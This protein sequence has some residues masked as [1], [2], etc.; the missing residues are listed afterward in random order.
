LVF[1]AF[2][3][4]AVVVGARRR[5]GQAGEG[6]QE[7]RPFEVFVTAAGR[8]FAA[9]GAAGAAGDRGQAGVGGQVPGGG[10]RSGVADFEQ[11]A[12]CGPDP[13]A[14][15]RDQDLGKR[16]GIKDPFDFAGDLVAL[17]QDLTQA[18]GRPG[19]HGLG[20]GGAGH[21]HGLL[22]QGGVDGGDEASAHARGVLD[23]DRGQ[24]AAS[25]LGQ[26]GRSAAAGEQLQ[27]GGVGGLR[28]DDPFQR[29]MDV[30]EQATDAVGQPGGLAGQVVV[31]AD[32]HTQLGQSLIAGVDPAQGVRQGPGGIGDDVG[33]AG[34]GLRGAGVQ[35]G[36]PTHRQSWQV[37]HLAARYPGDRDR[38]RARSR[39]AGR[40]RPTP[41]RGGTVCRTTPSIVLRCWAAARRAA[42]CRPA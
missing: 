15:H 32:Q 37:G 29:G 1:L 16:V 36:Q 22:V 7:E 19:Q 17:T 41:A 14:G 26:A 18:V 10:E 30:G 3:A 40:P 38:Q 8:V 2:S 42:A 34:V 33:V 23:R 28:A 24:L 4:F 9:D 6:G 31:E 13:D 35:V 39:R 21:H 27:Y 12:G 11:D 20:G 5:V 25:G